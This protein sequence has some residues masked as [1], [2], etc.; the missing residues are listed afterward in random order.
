MYQVIVKHNGN[1]GEITNWLNHNIIHRF[2]H[3]VENFSP[4][5]EAGIETIFLKF[6][7]QKDAIM[8]ELKW[9]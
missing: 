5:N 6:E 1:W 4:L 7:D 2:T 3:S 9:G 8:C